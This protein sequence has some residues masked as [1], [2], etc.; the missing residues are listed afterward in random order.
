MMQLSNE[1][2]D[3]LKNFAVINSNIAFT[4]DQTLKTVAVSKNLMAK[5]TVTETFP[6]EFGVYDLPEFLSAMSMFDNPELTFDD[7]QKFVTLSDNDASIKYFFSDVNNLVTAKNEPKLPDVVL[8]FTLSAQ[9]LNSIRKASA[10]LK[11]DH[12]VVTV[13]N[14]GVNVTV[15]DPKNATSNEFRLSVQ[16]SAKNSTADTNFKFNINNFKFNVSDKYTFEV[17]SKNIA[18][19]MSSDTQYWLALE[20]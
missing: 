20:K 15:T 7:S 1:T 3:V 19:V 11:V 17:S 18:S 14:N 13:D 8:T 9:Q 6:Y 10:A 2:V 5:A 12:L 16:G 4:T